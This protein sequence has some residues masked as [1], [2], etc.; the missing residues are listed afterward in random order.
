MRIRSMPAG[1]VLL[2]QVAARL[3]VLDVACNCCDRHGRLHT[4]RLLTTHGADLGD[5]GCNYGRR[6]HM[7]GSRAGVAALLAGALTVSLGDAPATAQVG[8]LPPYLQET[9]AQIGP[10]FQRDIQKTIPATVAAFQSILKSAPK[11]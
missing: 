8:R 7:K 5:P 10:V 2:G 1:V 6:R 11:F 3:S 4:S 9:L